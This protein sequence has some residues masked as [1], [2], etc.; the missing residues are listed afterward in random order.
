MEKNKKIFTAAFF[1]IVLSM[2]VSGLP[3]QETFSTKQNYNKKEV[4]IP[5]RDGVELFTQVYTPKDQSQKYPIM[6]FRTPY[7]IRF[8]GPK[9][10]RLTLGPNP[11][12]AREGFIFVYQDVRGKYQSE[13]EFIVMSPFIKGKNN[14]A[15]TDESSDNYDTI[16]WLLKNIP[17]NNERVGRWGIS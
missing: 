5:M 7:G 11:L 8:Y 13:G 15:V 1:S 6:L 14:T 2:L 3:A 16:D 12:Y 4:M 10:N 17:N 9:I